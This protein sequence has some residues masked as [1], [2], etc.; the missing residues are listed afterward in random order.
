MS[1]LDH[2]NII[3]LY[4]VVTKIEPIMIIMEFMENGS[5]YHYLKVNYT[6]ILQLAFCIPK[7]NSSVLKP[8]LKTFHVSILCITLHPSVSQ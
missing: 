5:L 2:P 8:R 4:G 6:Y 3:K 7:T 1:R